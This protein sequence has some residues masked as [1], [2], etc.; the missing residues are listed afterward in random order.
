MLNYRSIDLA[1]RPLCAKMKLQIDRL[2]EGNGIFCPPQS[3]NLLAHDLYRIFQI[4]Q[5]L[6]VDHH[7]LECVLYDAHFISIFLE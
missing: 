2:T 7:N 6:C 1:V 3:I 4:K 5:V